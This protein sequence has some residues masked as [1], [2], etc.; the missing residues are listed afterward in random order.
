MNLFGTRS[1]WLDKFKTSFR[2]GPN[3]GN[4]AV[5]DGLIECVLSCLLKIDMFLLPTIQICSVFYL[6]YLFELSNK[7]YNKHCISIGG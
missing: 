1:S 5:W 4:A 2:V 7:M 6:H 3:V